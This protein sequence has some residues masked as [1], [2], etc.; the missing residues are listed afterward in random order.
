MPDE[1]PIWRRD[2]PITAAG[3]D[4]V[5]RRDFTRY[6]VLASG[7]FAGSGA[8]VSLWASLRRVEAGVPTAVVALEDI[9]VGGSH[10]F[11]YPTSRDPAIVVRVDSDVVL[12]FSQKCTHLGCVVFW[13]GED[14][15]FE[16][17]CH[18]GFFDLDGRPFAGPP[19]RPLARIEIEVRDGVVWALGGGGHG[20]KA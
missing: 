20:Q 6:L 12:G 9:P 3:E 19:E 15:H 13:S 8:L 10:L 4:D 14:Q 5:T 16:C 18:E 2:F 7:A 11:Q 1:G 17:P